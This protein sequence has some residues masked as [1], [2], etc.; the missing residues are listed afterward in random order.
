[1]LEVKRFE[2]AREMK[3]ITP[4]CFLFLF[5]FIIPSYSSKYI[6]NFDFVTNSSKNNHKHKQFK[7]I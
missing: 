1:M 6:V 2:I 7:Q 4:L 5:P 3:I